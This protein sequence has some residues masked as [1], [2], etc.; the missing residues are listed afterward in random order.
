MIVSVA[1]S[2][3]PIPPEEGKETS[4]TAGLASE[5]SRRISPSKPCWGELFTRAPWSS[6]RK[7]VALREKKAMTKTARTAMTAEVMLGSGIFP[8]R[9]FASASLNVFPKGARGLGTQGDFS[10][11]IGF[12]FARL[13]AFS[14]SRGSMGFAMGGSENPVFFAMVSAAPTPCFFAPALFSMGMY[15]SLSKSFLSFSSSCFGGRDVP[16][17][18]LAFFL[19]PVSSL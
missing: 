18:L 12:S 13:F 4:M 10:F 16:R 19:F 17:Y 14:F 3:A 7:P 15:S 1:F 5:T 11:P 8:G 9:I 2:T 6:T